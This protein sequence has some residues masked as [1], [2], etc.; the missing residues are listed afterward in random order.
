MVGGEGW[1][2]PCR[3]VTLG[4]S[5]T[6][7]RFGGQPPEFP[8]PHSDVIK[9]KWRHPTNMSWGRTKD[10]THHPFCTFSQ[11]VVLSIP[12][13][14]PESRSKPSTNNNTILRHT[15]RE[16]TVK[17]LGVRRGEIDS[18]H[19]CFCTHR[20]TFFLTNNYNCW[21]CWPLNAMT[22]CNH[23]HSR[24][25]LVNDHNCLSCRVT[26]KGMLCYGM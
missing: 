9:K 14:P 23:E 21:S 19:F 18:Q 1:L 3:Q 7:K 24:L 13:P 12:L 5:P 26:G 2:S 16:T 10:Q 20:N 11:V 6:P 17:T 8:Q 22:I 25:S 4:S 15:W